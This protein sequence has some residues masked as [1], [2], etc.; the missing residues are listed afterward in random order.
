[1]GVAHA[2]PASPL[3]VE[4]GECL[5][6][7]GP[8]PPA[9]RAEI[10]RKLGA[11]PGWLPRV[12][13]SPWVSGVCRDLVASPFAFVSP[14]LA[15]LVALVVSQDNSCRY[16][17][18]VQRALLKI[19]RHSDQELD[20]LLHGARL[21]GL[22]P[23]ENAALELAR[24]VSRG[25]PRLSAADIER[26]VSAGLE[27]TA[28]IEVVGVA[29]ASS[30]MNRLATLLAL[31][32]EPLERVVANP[33]F[34]IVRPLMAWWMRP[35][36]PAPEPPLS[37][38]GPWARIPAALGRS[39]MAG[40]IRRTIDAALASPVL[41]RRTKLLMLAVVGRALECEY[42][43]GE[44]R[45][46]L[47]EDG[48]DQATVDEVLASLGSRRLEP[49]EIRLVGLARESVRYQPATIQRR[50]R[51]ACAGMS[52]EETLEAAATASLGNALCRLSAV[53]DVC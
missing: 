21:A 25:Q 50:V 41:P 31:P 17:Y 2:E 40:V 47:A 53:L 6:S 38:G 45:R 26:V 3:D 12:G 16:C 11:V 5:V 49:R 9:L 51:E 52:P 32:P 36:P 24:K 1:M 46:L 34:Q 43:V 7:A 4:W 19:F 15:D 30:F 23:A 28:V 8:V 29:A 27:R 44:A 10:R 20:R 35:H 33:L 18:G 39:P 42:S 22:S 48:V 37:G 14:E 13:R